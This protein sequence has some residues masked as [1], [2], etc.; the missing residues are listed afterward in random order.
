MS[1]CH[2]ALF[3]FAPSF[4]LDQ[5]LLAERY[6]E[7]ARETH[8]D[9]FADASDREQRQALT[10]AAEL[11]D[12]YQVLKTPSR[13]AHYLLSLHGDCLPLE[14]TVQDPEFLMQQM[15]LREEL[16]ELQD[17]ADVAGVASFK[18]RLRIS[19]TH[20]ERDFSE[21]WANPEERMQAERL[22]RRLQFL[23]K[24]ARE[25]RDLEERLDD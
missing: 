8:P 17:S 18:K 23:D 13:R 15:M 4:D 22:M 2:F 9:R 11:N 1:T 3:G 14:A 21:C 12:A 6:R 7:L 24:L 10:R 20:L 25:V 5:G 19:Q 16:E